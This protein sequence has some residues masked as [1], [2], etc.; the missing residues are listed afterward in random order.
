VSLLESAHYLLH[1][2]REVRESAT[3]A[4][5]AASMRRGGCRVKL[6]RDDSRISF[7]I[8]RHVT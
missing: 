6:P 2:A 5:G 1:K 4:T 7:R 3:S 8:R